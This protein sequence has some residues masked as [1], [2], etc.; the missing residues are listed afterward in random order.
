MRFGLRKSTTFPVLECLET[1]DLVGEKVQLFQFWSTWEHEI[2]FEKRYTFSSFGVPANLLSEVNKWYNFSSFGVPGNLLSEVNRWSF[3]N[4]VY[5]FYE[6]CS[7]AFIYVVI[8]HNINPLKLTVTNREK[9]IA[10][11]K[12]I[13]MN[14]LW[15]SKC[16]HYIMSL[17]LY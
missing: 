8:Q 17:Y 14:Y 5:L 1:W 4:N 2:W 13:S 9:M 10:V 3:W 11:S 16:K 6:Y 12:R 15:T 7:D